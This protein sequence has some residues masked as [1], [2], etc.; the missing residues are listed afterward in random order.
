[1]RGMFEAIFKKTRRLIISGL[2][3]GRVGINTKGDVTKYFDKKVENEI[4]FEIKKHVKFRAC[5]IS[6]EIKNPFIINP[7]AKTGLHYIVIDPVDGSDNYLARVPFVATAIAV[8][9]DKLRP[10]YS[11]VGNYYTGDFIYA[12][13]KAAFFNSKKFKGPFI[14]PPKDLLILTVSKTKTKNP[15]KF[16]ALADKFDIVRSFGATAGEMLLVAKGEAKAFVDVRGSL[17]LENF[18][19]YFLIARHAGLKMTDHTGRDIKLTSLSMKK[20]YKLIFA[21]R[22]FLDKITAETRLI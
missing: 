1:M 18:A 22:S 5:I 7:H 11:F 2:P 9:D 17:T 16:M 19:P 15:A 12:D 21:R 14:R 10:V 13:K 3:A 8:F 20:G 4:I 6:E